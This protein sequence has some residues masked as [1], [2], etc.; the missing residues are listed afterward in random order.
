MGFSAN[1][2]ND[3]VLFIQ[4]WLIRAVTL[5]LLGIGFLIP[6]PAHAQDAVL[7]CRVEPANIGINEEATLYIEVA[8]IQNLYGYQLYMNYDAQ[9]LAIQ[10]MDPEQIGVNLQLGDFVVPDFLLKNIATESTGLIEIVLTQVVP[11]PP[12]SGGGILA[13]AQ[14]TGRAEGVARLSFSLESPADTLLSD[15]N[16]IALTI[17]SADPCD[18]SIGAGAQPTPTPTLTPTPQPIP[19]TATPTATPTFTPTPVNVDGTGQHQDTAPT[20]TPTAIP[21]WT[22][23]H[24]P[25]PPDQGA[26]QDG[27]Q[28][29]GQTT[30]QEGSVSTPAPPTPTPTDTVVV[31]TTPTPNGNGEAGRVD[32]A[33]P[34]PVAPQQTGAEPTPD[35]A[36][37]LAVAEA[38]ARDAD[39]PPGDAGG[40]EDAAISGQNDSALQAEPSATDPQAEVESDGQEPD[41][42][43]ALPVPLPPTPAL[44]VERLEQPQ[45]TAVGTADLPGRTL[46]LPILLGLVVS[47]L[48]GVVG[49]L[50][51]WRGRSS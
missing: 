24:T 15:N 51:F 48:L 30:G 46:L 27:G 12:V 17:A 10:D 40:P 18:L 28:G 38:P 44:P 3:N 49:I 23:T 19:A 26:G 14:V 37:P 13:T 4:K 9:R 47:A 32:P 41:E 29:A 20:A 2:E 25:L 16:G 34:T 21:T 43:A 22:P 45:P 1:G 42:I 11:S 36:M 39:T 7:R 5:A 8:N 6:A 35:A 50:F 33:T 31:I